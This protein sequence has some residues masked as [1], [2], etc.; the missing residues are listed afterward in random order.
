MTINLNKT[1]YTDSE[2]VAAVQA[3]RDAGK[4]ADIGICVA[5]TDPN[6]EYWE[7]FEFPMLVH[8][9]DGGSIRCIWRPTK[10]RYDDALNRF[11]ISHICDWDT[12]DEVR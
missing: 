4:Y 8:M 12:I 1:N 5:A 2:I 11:D 7:R 10:D 3:A 6:L 9:P